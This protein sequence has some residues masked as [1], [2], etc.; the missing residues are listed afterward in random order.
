AK[1]N[2]LALLLRDRKGDLGERQKLLE[3]AVARQKAALARKPSHPNYRR[4]LGHHYMNLG[5]V[6]VE[7][8]QYAEAEKC[9]SQC[10]EIR[11]KLAQE[12]SGEPGYQADVRQ[13]KTKLGELARLQSKKDR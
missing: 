3:Q 5:D 6:L 7:L 2:D 9:F 13:I 8:G 10:L 4:F 11:E 1:L 12:R